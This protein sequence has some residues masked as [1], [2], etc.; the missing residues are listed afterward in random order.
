[1]KVRV[2]VIA[3]C[4]AAALF[5]GCSSKA[6]EKPEKISE[7]GAAETAAPEESLPEDSFEKLPK[8][9]EGELVAVSDAAHSAFPDAKG[10]KMFGFKGT[11]QLELDGVTEDCYIF[12]Y[13]TY[14]SKTYTK[15]ATLAKSVADESIFMLD[16]ATGEYTPY[17]VSTDEAADS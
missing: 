11:E 1:M 14:K 2:S 13:Y 5:C 15:I 4:L 3:V 12:D 17:T 7:T 9:A 10:K 16:D 8:G 6:A